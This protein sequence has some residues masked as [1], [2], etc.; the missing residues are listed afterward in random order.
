MRK[1]ALACDL[2]GTFIK[3]NDG[4]DQPR[5]VLMEDQERV[6]DFVSNGHLYIVSTGRTKP[7]TYK[8]FDFLDLHLE[9]AYYITSNGAQIYDENRD[10]IYSQNIPD[11]V[12]ATVFDA[13]VAMAQE[14][15]LECEVY[16][17]ET[18]YQLLSTDKL[19]KMNQVISMCVASIDSSIDNARVFYNHVNDNI[20]TAAVSMNNWYVDIIPLNLSKAS[21]IKH[22]LSLQDEE[23]E[24][25][26]IG[27]SWNDTPMFEIA[28]RSF[29]FNSS[30]QEVKDKATNLIDHFYQCVDILLDK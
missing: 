11:D 28:N 9:N 10:C 15:N 1:I 19:P 26:A 6:K 3:H 7:V 8:L 27:D 4:K 18:N 17:G 29:T 12:V 24:L 14:L 2:D 22:I 16:D 5:S 23:Y 25:V 20:S 21:A 13:F 30:P